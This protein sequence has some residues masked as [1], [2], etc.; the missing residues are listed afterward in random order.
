M[1]DGAQVDKKSESGV[2]RSIKNLTDRIKVNN[3]L[4]DKLVSRLDHILIKEKVDQD[5]ERNDDK[6]SGESNLTSTINTL[7]DHL[8][9]INV[10]LED[11]ISILDL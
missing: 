11:T 8:T 3:E 2:N 10:K 1:L 9:N 5:N 4:V 6:R 7:A